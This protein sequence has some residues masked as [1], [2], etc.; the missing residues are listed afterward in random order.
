MIAYQKKFL[1]IA[2]YW[3][4]EPERNPKVDLVR[5]F[6]YSEPLANAFCREFY[7]IVLNL[8]PNKGDLF[9]KMKR[10]TRYEIRRAELSDQFLYQVANGEDSALLSEFI[11]NHDQFA[12]HKAQAKINH[13]WVSTIAAAGLLQISRVQDPVGRTLVWHAY[14]IGDERATLL[15]SASILRPESDGNLRTRVGRANRYHHWQDILHFKEL[16]LTIYDFGGWYEKKEDRARLNIN[17]FKE[18]FGGDI[19]KTYICERPLTLRGWVFLKTR[20]LLLGNAI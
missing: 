20:T 8:Q 11:D 13:L 12:A 1:R 5:F 16:G 6:Q 9:S 15:Y 2:E 7:S 10:N 4:A 19:V 17:K 3:G 18:G 14:H